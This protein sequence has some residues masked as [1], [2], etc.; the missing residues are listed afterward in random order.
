[1]E[2]LPDLLTYFSPP[3]VYAYFGLHAYSIQQYKLQM[4]RKTESH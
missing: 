4:S 2:Q 1:M 3:I